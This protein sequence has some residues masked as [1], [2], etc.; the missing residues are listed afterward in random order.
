[1][2]YFGNKLS[3]IYALILHLLMLRDLRT[4]YIAIRSNKVVCFDTNLKGFHK[5][6]LICLPEI[7]LGYDSFYSKLQKVNELQFTVN[8]DQTVYIEKLQV[9]E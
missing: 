9:N 8:D 1:M 6:L 7:A 3:N 5:K 4:L 2:F